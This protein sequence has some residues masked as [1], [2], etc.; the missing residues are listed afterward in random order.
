VRGCDW[1]WET[2]YF[3]PYLVVGVAEAGCGDFDEDILRTRSRKG[4]FLDFIQRLELF[5]VNESLSLEYIHLKSVFR[6][7]EVS[8]LPEQSRTAFIVKR[9]VSILNQLRMDF[10]LL[11][12]R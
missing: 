1:Q 12:H 5:A 7:V 9:K 6:E 4:D 11:V 2:I 10:V 8:C 3:F